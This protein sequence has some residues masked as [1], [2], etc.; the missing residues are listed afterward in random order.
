MATL[1]AFFATAV[2]LAAPSMAT[3]ATERI[4]VTD[5]GTFPPPGPYAGAVLRVNPTNGV[6]T[7]VSD[8]GHPEVG[9][10]FTIPYRLALE[11]DGDILVVD[12]DSPFDSSGRVIRVDPVTGV[13][14]TVSANGSPPGGPD[15]PEPFAIALEADGHILVADR[16]SAAVIR[17]DPVTGTRTL[18]S[19]NTSPPGEPGFA[20]PAGLAVGPDGDIWVV[21]TYAGGIPGGAVIRVDSVTGARTLVSANANPTG[22]PSFLEPLAIALEA[23]GNILVGNYASGNGA[24][25]RVDPVTG[26]RTTVSSNTSPPGGPSLSV[27]SGITVDADGSILVADSGTVIR[28]DPVTG[29]RTLVSNNASPAGDPSFVNPT[30]VAVMAVTNQPPDCSA[31]SASPSVVPAMPKGRF[32]TVSLLG[33]SDADADTLSFHI[34]S[35]TQDE[36][37]FGDSTAP[38]AQFT[39]AGADSNQVLVRAERDTKGNGRVYRIFYTVSDGADSCSDVAKVSV[40]R[41]KGQVAVDSAPPSFDSLTGAQL[42]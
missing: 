3:A 6:R 32:T 40:P 39:A 11:P 42:P 34:S 19:S 18:V 20:A 9:P 28:I 13:R 25:L 8:V 23:N 12:R 7:T 22:E 31:V 36:P 24:V 27:P 1:A 21:D 38:D 17:V 26:A 15:L 35:V 2:C 10:F 41:K 37:V 14:T 16:D 29:A 5:P 33:A 30:G 4:F